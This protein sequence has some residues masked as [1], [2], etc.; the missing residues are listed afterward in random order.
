MEVY[1]R[2]G[3]RLKQIEGEMVEQGMDPR[4]MVAR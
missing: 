2:N 4:G 1:G 3:G